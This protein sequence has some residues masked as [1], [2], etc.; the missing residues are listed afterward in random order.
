ME[1]IGFGRPST[2]VFTFYCKHFYHNLVV[3]FIHE[4][5]ANVHQI[6]SVTYA[7][8]FGGDRCAGR[9][10]LQYCERQSDPANDQS[11]FKHQHSEREVSRKL[12]LAFKTKS[13]GI[14]ARTQIS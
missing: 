13:G 5:S 3:I 12:F 8:G 14:A 9:N 7:G 6:I 2:A 1:V 4:A 10:F 11:T